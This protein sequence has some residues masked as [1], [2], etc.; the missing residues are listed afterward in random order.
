MGGHTNHTTDD[1][2]TAAHAGD[3]ALVYFPWSDLSHRYGKAR[4]STLSMG[5]PRLLV[6]V[7]AV[8]SCDN[9]GTWG[10]IPVFIPF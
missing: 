5:V 7:D 1:A 4:L 10:W 8:N 2:G 6:V 9:T 3:G